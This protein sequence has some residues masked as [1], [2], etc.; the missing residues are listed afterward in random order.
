[1]GKHDIWQAK[2]YTKKPDRFR[3]SFTRKKLIDLL[4]YKFYLLDSENKEVEFIDN[5]KKISTLNY[6]TEVLQCTIE[7][8]ANWKQKKI[9]L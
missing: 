4:S 3:F 9:I 7:K 5:E 2:K 1:M 6:E 8:N